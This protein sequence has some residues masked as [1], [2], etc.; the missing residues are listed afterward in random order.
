MVH[1]LR[2]LVVVCFPFLL[3]IFGFCSAFC[4]QRTGRAPLL[5]CLS[6]LPAPWLFHWASLTG[7]AR[8][9]RPVPTPCSPAQ[10]HLCNWEDWGGT[11]GQ[12]PDPTAPLL[13]LTLGA[14]PLGVLSTRTQPVSI[15]PQP[16]CPT[17]AIDPCL[18]GSPHAPPAPPLIFFSI[19]W[20]RWA[21]T[22][23]TRTPP[24]QLGREISRD[25]E[26]VGATPRQQDGH[27]AGDNPWGRW[28]SPP[29]AAPCCS[30]L[31]AVARGGSGERAAQPTAADV[32]N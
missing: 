19:P 11:E 9:T 12:G 21:R 8:R 31:R 10:S 1:G 26:H 28:R 15:P 24:L 23:L 7:A 20:R 27:P 32:A 14:G 5:R 2:F 6:L 4:L 13:P 3:S 16:C 17:R 30:Q 22:H 18:E 25:E 29:R